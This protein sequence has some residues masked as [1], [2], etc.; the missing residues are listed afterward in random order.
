MKTAFALIFSLSTLAF[1]TLAEDN[2]ATPDN[3]T[4]AKRIA[5]VNW[6]TQS[7]KLEWAVQSGVM[8]DGDFVPSSE[9]THYEITP[10]QA[11]MAFQGQQRG[12]TGQEAEWLQGLL[13]VLTVYCAESTVWWEQGQGLPLDHDQKPTGQPPADKSTDPDTSPHKVITPLPRPTPGAIRLVAMNP[14]R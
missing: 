13:H 5:S 9:E 4:P 11:M 8:R 6:N 7:G 10:E 12:F 2:P 3:G 1:T 14:I